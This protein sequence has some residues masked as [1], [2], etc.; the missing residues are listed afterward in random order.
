MCAM[1]VTRDESQLVISKDAPESFAEPAFWNEYEVSVSVSGSRSMYCR[2][3]ASLK[4]YRAD[5][6]P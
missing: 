6:A 3:T 5:V 4:A 1:V 2:W